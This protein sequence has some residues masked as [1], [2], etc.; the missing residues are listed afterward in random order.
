MYKTLCNITQDEE[1]AND[2][3]FNAIFGE[4][5]SDGFSASLLTPTS[6]RRKEIS[7]ILD[8]KNPG[9]SDQHLDYR[10]QETLPRIEEIGFP[11]N[12]KNPVLPSSRQEASRRGV[13][14]GFIF[15][16]ESENTGEQQLQCS[17]Q[18]VPEDTQELITTFDDKN[19]NP[20]DLQLQQVRARGREIS[21]LFGASNRSSLDTQP[22][23]SQEESAE[24]EETGSQE[25]PLETEI[26]CPI[27]SKNL[28][29]LDPQLQEVLGVNISFDFDNANSLSSEIQC[30]QQ[31]PV[32]ETEDTSFPF[33]ET[34]QK[35]LYSQINCRQQEVPTGK[36]KL[37]VL[38]N[39]NEQRILDPL[40]RYN[41]TGAVQTERIVPLSTKNQN[42][43]EPKPNY[44]QKETHE[45]PSRVIFFN[46]NNQ[47]CFVYQPQAGQE[48]ITTKQREGKD[49][50][51]PMLTDLTQKSEI[52]LK[53]GEYPQLEHSIYG[54]SHCIFTSTS[55]LEV[56]RH[57]RTHKG[58]KSYACLYCK[59][60]CARKDNMEAHERTHTKERPHA[61]SYCSYTCSTKSNLRSHEY[62]HSRVGE[63]L[64]CDR[65]SF[66]TARKDCFKRHL[67]IH[68]RQ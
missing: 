31:E 12:G 23:C 7:L 65:C 41:Y 24:T 36:R 49:Q 25:E 43:L 2:D 34:K 61:C 6:D 18:K 67:R 4:I 37:F 10:R 29:D 45:G 39:A 68:A 46:V 13:N 27:D 53:A 35:F 28:N 14:V 57:V 22:R 62:I 3:E 16:A 5:L 38:L 40:P 55:K 19:K 64:A 21:S 60:V 56:E 8:G 50:Y 58:K 42:N 1:T 20:L 66:I 9:R 44:S 51:T 33:D 52:A 54:C 17:Q 30:S 15:N 47:K 48:R 63:R 26:A 32:L 59:Y 11:F